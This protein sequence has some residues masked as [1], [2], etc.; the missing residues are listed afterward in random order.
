[1]SV[2]APVT[3]ETTSQ[4]SGQTGPK[5]M[6]QDE[7][8]RLLVTQLKNQDPLKPVDNAAFVAELAQF[9]QLEQSVKQ[10]A[11]L[12][13]SIQSQQIA[14]QYSV[15][16]LVGRQVQVDGAWLQLGDGPAAL[17]YATEQDAA[18]VRI[19]IHDGKG[20]AVRSLDLGPVGAGAHRVVWDGLDANGNPAPAGSYRYMVAARDASGNAVPVDTVSTLTVTGVWLENG[21]PQIMVGD[22]LIDPSVV[23]AVH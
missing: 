20:H 19:T 2:I 18:S 17:T 23:L 13:Q 11:L 12:E 8:L 15:L 4:P 21:H 16:P 7:F 6:G 1:M 5:A 14:L 10:V 9:S 22:H 3:N